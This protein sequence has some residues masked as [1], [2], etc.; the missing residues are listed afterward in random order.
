[1]SDLFPMRD[2]AGSEAINQE[3][4]QQILAAI[5]AKQ[6]IRFLY[7]GKER[8]AEPHDYGIH[9]A[10]ARLFTYQIAGASGGKLPG[11][12]WFDVA[13]MSEITLLEKRFAGG[14]PGSGNH[15]HWD[16]L[17]ARVDHP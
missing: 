3:T 1:M 2:A 7:G 9:K 15:H 12:R 5:A 13:G 17:F 10:T 6:L 14:R 4:H 16:S 8:I 11:W